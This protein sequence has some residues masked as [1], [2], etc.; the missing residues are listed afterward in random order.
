MKLAHGISHQ[1]C[2]VNYLWN[3]DTLHG[4]LVR[5]ARHH[6]TMA[7]YPWDIQNIY[8][9]LAKDSEIN[10]MQKHA[11]DSE[12]DQT[13]CGASGRSIAANRKDAIYRMRPYHRS[14]A[15][16]SCERFPPASKVRAC[17]AWDDES[18]I[19]MIGPLAADEWLLEVTCVA[20]P[21]LLDLL[22]RGMGTCSVST[23]NS[24]SCETRGWALVQHFAVRRNENCL[25][26]KEA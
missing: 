13:R 24:K 10:E 14:C 4:S 22:N 25:M 3:H 9:I 6:V 12:A 1:S 23:A 20:R 21:S 18:K 8:E 19:A 2:S 7:D 17:A 11:K 26:P 15:I 16:A 5:K